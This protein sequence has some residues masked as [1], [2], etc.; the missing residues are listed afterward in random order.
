MAKP[1][2]PTEHSDSRIAFT[3]RQ[4]VIILLAAIA[5]LVTGLLMWAG[6]ASFPQSILSSLG[7]CAVSL[8]FF[9]SIIHHP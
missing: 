8:K 9:D 2:D 5:G 7:A 3:I 6:G 1:E 4:V